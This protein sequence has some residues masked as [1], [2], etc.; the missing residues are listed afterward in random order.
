MS[1]SEKGSL[2]P[3]IY[4]YICE[5]TCTQNITLYLF[6]G[7]YISSKRKKKTDNTKCLFDRSNIIHTISNRANQIDYLYANQS[8]YIRPGSSQNLYL[9]EWMRVCIPFAF[10]RKVNPIV[11][12]GIYTI[13]N[14]D[15]FLMFFFFLSSHPFITFHIY[16]VWFKRHPLLG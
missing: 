10:D 12:S 3:Y 11:L 2:H 5:Y 9:Y 16:L 15:P 4:K 8:Q 7:L 13:L 1:L 6:C 14:R